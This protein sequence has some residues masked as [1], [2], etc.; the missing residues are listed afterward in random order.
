MKTTIKKILKVICVLFTLSAVFTGCQQ[1]AS[2]SEYDPLAH[3]FASK[4]PELLH[5][6]TERTGWTNYYLFFMQ[7]N[8]F[9]ITKIGSDHAQNDFIRGDV[10]LEK[11][12]GS[13]VY[14]KLIPTWNRLSDENEPILF[15][16]EG[17]CKYTE[18]EI[19]INLTHCQPN[20]DRKPNY[21]EYRRSR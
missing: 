2:D 18:D 6:F 19:V 3:D 20:G 21:M 9:K 14:I 13:T 7:N 12:V 15:W 11:S 16:L 17:E 5:Q 10:I 8:T 4:C 1:G